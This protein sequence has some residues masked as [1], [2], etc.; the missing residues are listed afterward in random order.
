MTN[1]HCTG[2]AVCENWNKVKDSS[3]W[4]DDTSSCDC[5]MRTAKVLMWCTAADCCRHGTA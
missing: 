3:I 4:R 2:T 5:R 1:S